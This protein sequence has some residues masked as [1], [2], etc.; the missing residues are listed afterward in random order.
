[1]EIEEGS[2]GIWNIV[3]GKVRELS[4]T[5]FLAAILI[6]LDHFSFRFFLVSH[7]HLVVEIFHWM[8]CC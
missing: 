2:D 5:L 6:F 3:G 1:M 4:V 7:S 8:L